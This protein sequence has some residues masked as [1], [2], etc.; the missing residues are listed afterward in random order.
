[1]IDDALLKTFLSLMAFVA[2]IGGVLWYIKRKTTRGVVGQSTVAIRI[3]ARQALTPKSYVCIVEIRGG[4]YALGVTEQSVTLLKDIS[5]VVHHSAPANG[6]SSAIPVPPDDLHRELEHLFSQKQQP[7]T[8][9]HDVA[10][11][12]TA[13]PEEPTFGRYIAS[14][15][16]TKN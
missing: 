5:G 7:A 10:T 13:I 4:L 2:V 3:V 15:F 12:P 14:I 16:S 1:M 8:M 11:M 6:T 9:V